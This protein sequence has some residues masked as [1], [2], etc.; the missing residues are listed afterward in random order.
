LNGRVLIEVCC[1]SVDDVLEAQRGGAD[2]VEL[3]S[4]LLL[5]GLTPS[6]GSII[7]AKRVSKIPV[8]AMVRPR[9]GGFCYTE[10]E[11]N[12]MKYDV[13]NS[14]NLGADGIVFGIL[15]ENGEIDEKRCESIIKLSKDKEVVFHRAFDVVPDPI[16]SI[17]KLVNLGVKRI[18]TKGQQNTAFE[19]ADLLK[20]IIKYA[21]GR[22]EILVGGCNPYNVQSI[23]S[24]VGCDQIHIASFVPQADTSV[25]SRPNVYFG[26]ALRPPED[27]YD[28]ADTDYVRAMREK[29][30]LL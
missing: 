8:M 9:G 17:D 24:E 6:T 5:G 29:L 2:R 20:E 14:V 12:V 13:I 30:E 28:L 18:L 10:E 4:S 1:G 7:E 25:C 23:I 21:A 26:S 11:M 19:G 3:N 22:I 16:A 27:R 15:K